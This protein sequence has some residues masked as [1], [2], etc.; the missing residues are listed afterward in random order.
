MRRARTS[1][2]SPVPGPEADDRHGGHAPERPLLWD[3]EHDG[4]QIGRVTQHGRS[5][6]R[7]SAASRACATT[8]PPAHQRRHP[9]DQRD[10]LATPACLDGGAQPRIGKVVLG[11]RSASPRSDGQRD[12]HGGADDRQHHHRSARA[13]EQPGHERR[14]QRMPRT[15]FRRQVSQRAAVRATWSS[16]A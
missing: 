10:P 16:L 3:L 12:R 14:E 8:A 1:T 11:W 13:Q 4:A 5:A 2:F 6:V 15:A 7:S 9:G